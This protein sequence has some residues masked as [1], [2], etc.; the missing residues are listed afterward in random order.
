M[1]ILDEIKVSREEASATPIVNVPE[2]N[3][4]TPTPVEV[5]TA[6]E[7]TTIETIETAVEQPITNQEPIVVP[8]EKPKSQFANEEVAR[9]NAYLTKYPE[10][11]L[12]DYKALTTPVE[13]LQ[14]DDLLKSYLSEKEGK[15][16]SQI[17]YALKQLEL[18]EQDPDF[19]PEF[20]NDETALENLKRKGDRE[21]MIQKA[22]EWR[23]DFVKNE[24]NFDGDSLETQTPAQA[25]FP[26]IEKFV[27][28]AKNQHLEYLQN[29]RT[30]IYKALPDLNKIDLEVQGKTVSFV[31]DENFKT[32]MRK[33]AEDISQIGN[34]YF[35]EKQ[36][37][38]DAK[39]FITNNTLWA[40]PKTRQPMIDFMIEQAI[41]NDRANTDKLR[42]NITLDNADGRSVPQS[43]ERGDVVDKLFSRNR[44][45]F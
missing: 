33:G 27:E 12:D 7:E 8:E 16:K 37:I 20:E 30:E 14:E 25:E 19:D 34:E 17:E 38:K 45:G 13:S 11:T 40:N 39:G 36:N 6:P 10:K 35:D 9:M 22:R 29:Y 31:P 3:S 15:T 44:G 26:S 1:S 4:E 21:A 24:L 23:E 5:Q 18:K 42:R 32:E 28:D 41:L 2:E 43:T